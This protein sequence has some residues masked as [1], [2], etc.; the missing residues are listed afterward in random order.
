M[1]WV[2]DHNITTDNVIDRYPSRRGRD[3]F[4]NE[5]LQII[6]NFDLVDTARCIY[7]SR[8]DI[9]TWYQGGSASRIDKIIVQDS[10][11]VKQFTHEVS[12]VSDHVVIST[13]LQLDRV[14]ECWTGRWK[15]NV[16]VYDNDF[17][18]AEFKILWDNWK[19]TS[20]ATCP[21]KFWVNAKKK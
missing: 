1:I 8:N 16:S 10:F 20:T 14:Q 17:F 19:E 4:G 9:F 12:S 15:N 11:C 21:V 5:I 18:K 7:P 13:H 6:Q 3:T 2:G